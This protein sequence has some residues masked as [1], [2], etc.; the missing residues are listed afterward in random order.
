LLALPT[1]QSQV[2][3]LQTVLAHG[4]NVRQT[5]ELVRRLSGQRSAAPVKAVPPPEVNALEQRLQSALGTRVNLSRR[6]KGG[7][8]TIH[9]YSDEELDALVGR[10]LGSEE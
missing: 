7:V 5:E 2:A 1:T 8:I 10:L 4:L 6:R 9:Y 3:A